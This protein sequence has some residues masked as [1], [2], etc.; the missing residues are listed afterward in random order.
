MDMDETRK[1]YERAIGM[2]KPNPGIRILTCGC[3][4]NTTIQKDGTGRCDVSPCKE[5]CTNYLMVLQI[6]SNNGSQII[7]KWDE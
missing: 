5:T 7:H 6:A 4:L 3:L 2:N 1:A